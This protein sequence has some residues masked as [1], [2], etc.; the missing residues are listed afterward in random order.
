[1]Y[2]FLCRSKFSNDPH[3]QT[4]LKGGI[5]EPSLELRFA[6]ART[7]TL[8]AANRRRSVITL[9]VQL[10]VKT[11]SRTT[12]QFLSHKSSKLDP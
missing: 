4:S 7:S 2:T 5:W 1:M 9:I 8:K 11:Q 3:P 6:V 10:L 12:E